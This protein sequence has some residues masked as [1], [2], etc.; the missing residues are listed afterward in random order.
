MHNFCGVVA[1]GYELGVCAFDVEV[2]RV[3]FVIFWLV[4]QNGQ[5]SISLFPGGWSGLVVSVV[6]WRSL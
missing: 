1:G 6:V 2:G 3:S 5:A 4:V